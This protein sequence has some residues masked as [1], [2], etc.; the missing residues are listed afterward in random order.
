MTRPAGSS[1]SADLARAA[2]LHRRGGSGACLYGLLAVRVGLLLVVGSLDVDRPDVV[3]GAVQDVVH[4][5]HRAAAS[6]GR[7]C[8]SGAARCG[9]PAGSP[10]A[11]VEP[12]ADRR[13]RARRSPRRT[14]DRPSGRARRS[15]GAPW[16]PAR[17]RAARARALASATRS[18]SSMLH[19]SSPSKQKYSM[20]T[21]AVSGSG[22]IHGR[23]GAE[24]L[25]AAD[26]DARPRGCRSSCR[27]TGPRRRG[28]ARRSG[29]RGSA[30]PWRPRRPSAGAAGRRCRPCSRS[31]S[32]EIVA[33]GLEDLVG[34]VDARR[35]RPSGD[36]DASWPASRAG[37]RRPSPRCARSSSPTS[38]PGRSGG[39]GTCRSAT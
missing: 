12:A 2:S 34:R 13:R 28:S 17:G 33:V 37:P 23:P 26:L 24:V 20:P 5:A 18:S 36:L 22:T 15:R 8:C 14:S 32:D 16:R 6:S 11:P 7:S 31:G 3:A 9:R 39:T 10:R 38:G 4:G 25:D 21:Q 27:G 30:G 19:S 35:R 29:S 1:C